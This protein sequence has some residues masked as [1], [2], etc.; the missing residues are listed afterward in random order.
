MQ[1]L[2]SRMTVFNKRVFPVIWFGFLILF[3]GVPIFSDQ[4]AN[5]ATALPFLFVPAIMIVAGYFIM[6]KLIFDLVDEVW[7]E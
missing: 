2:S 7:D 6:K 5:S 4:L 3:I 1:R